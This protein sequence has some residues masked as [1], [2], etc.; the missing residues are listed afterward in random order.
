MSLKKL[1]KNKN[2]EI[3]N[4]EVV[5]IDNIKTTK[6]FKKV[7]ISFVILF[8]LF[9]FFYTANSA[10]AWT[11]ATSCGTGCTWTP[12]SYTNTVTTSTSF[13]MNITSGYGGASASGCPG[14]FSSPTYSVTNN[15]A[16]CTITGSV[17]AQ[18]YGITWTATNGG[19]TPATCTF[20][21]TV[22]PVCTPNSG[23]STS[24]C[25]GAFTCATSN[26]KTATFTPNSYT[27][28]YAQ[29]GAT[30][31]SSPTSVTQNYATAISAPTS[32]SRTGYTFS[33]W[34]PVIPG[35]M[36][37]GGGT[38]TAQWTA[39]TTNTVTW[40]SATGG[41]SSG[42][43]TCSTGATVTP[44]CTPSTDYT[45]ASCASFTCLYPSNSFTPSFTPKSYTYTYAQNS[46]T[47]NSVP[48]SVT[49]N[50][51]T[52]ISAPTSPLRTGYVFNGWSPVIPG[53]MPSL[54]G[55]STAQWT[56]ANVIPSIG[57]PSQSSVSLTSATLGATITSAGVPA[58]I[59]DRGTCV[60][61]TTGQTNC[62]SEGGTTVAA[63]SHSRTGFSMLCAPVRHD[64]CE[65]CQ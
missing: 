6:N 20:N 37:V 3:N 43:A 14:S 38:S 26:S 42:V 12:T 54:G 44:T 23:Y 51:G 57:T 36:P 62:V 35:T 64:R 58:T 39:I 1:M 50:Y 30:T 46:A 34:S 24:V 5:N 7:F 28:T 19:A 41:T 16:A 10:S 27:Y 29:N 61:T 45:T 55:T 22:T 47:T 59:T 65:E 63:F 49:Q 13:T 17:A 32:P 4:V 8:S 31:N 9:S 48:T 60:D 33:S 11:I 15:N 21:A 18:T 40:N 56:S 53:T 2:L 25:P 52:A